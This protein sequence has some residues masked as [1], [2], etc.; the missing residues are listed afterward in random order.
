[1][2]SIAQVT[3]NK[4][5]NVPE[6]DRPR[7]SAIERVITPRARLVYTY[8]I[9]VLYHGRNVGSLEF[10]ALATPRK[11]GK[12]LGLDARKDAERNQRELLGHLLRS[13]LRK[14]HVGLDP[15]RLRPSMQQR[16][17]ERIHAVVEAAK[18]HRIL[19]GAGADEMIDEAIHVFEQGL[20]VVA[21]EVARVLSHP[22]LQ[23][24][25][26]SMTQT[27]RNDCSRES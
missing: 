13:E 3:N 9:G 24:L 6:E 22:L 15:S 1:M 26:D 17:S 10:L 16:C 20:G 5:N 27:T 7:W 21:K 23:Y 11:L 8:S 12:L 19:A 18:L 25:H 14:E 2:E 4:N